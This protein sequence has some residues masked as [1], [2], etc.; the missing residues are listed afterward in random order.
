MSFLI[1]A[2]DVCRVQGYKRDD[3]VMFIISELTSVPELLAVLMDSVETLH[4]IMLV[5]RGNLTCNSMR[6]VLKESG[7]EGSN[8]FNFL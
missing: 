1:L 3:S 5:C 7:G 6:D 4:L 8:G 2:D